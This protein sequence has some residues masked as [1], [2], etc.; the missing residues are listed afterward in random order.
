MFGFLGPLHAPAYLRFR[1]PGTCHHAQRLTELCLVLQP[2]EASG[3]WK[4]RDAEVQ[5]LYYNYSRRNLEAKRSEWKWGKGEKVWILN[6]NIWFL[7]FVT[8]FDDLCWAYGGNPEIPQALE[9]ELRELKI[10][11]S[12][13]IYVL[14][15]TQST[16]I[17]GRS[18]GKR[19]GLDISH[20]IQNTILDKFTA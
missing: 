15:C 2:D 5:S 11:T 8:Y 4:L 19:Q 10:A 17:K 18:K 6:K 20:Q 13:W 12:C 3:G 14:Y 9:V 1:R 7:F 16:C